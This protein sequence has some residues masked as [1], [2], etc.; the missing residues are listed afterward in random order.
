MKPVHT[1]D[2]L[3]YNNEGLMPPDIVRQVMQR[4]G[5]YDL[6]TID[7]KRFKADMN[8]KH[9]HKLYT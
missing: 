1:P 7:Y 2:N 8:R 3:S 9:K 5:K 6:A 4:Y